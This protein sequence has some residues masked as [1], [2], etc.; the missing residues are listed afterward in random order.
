MGTWVPACPGAG[1]LSAE[2]MLKQD[3]RYKCVNLKNKTAL[4]LPQVMLA[5]HAIRK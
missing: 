5:K 3:A 1:R 4:I 2:D